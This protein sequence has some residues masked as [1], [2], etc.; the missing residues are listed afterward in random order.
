MKFHFD[1]DASN[2]VGVFG[3]RL[4]KSMRLHK[5]RDGFIKNSFQANNEHGCLAAKEL[6]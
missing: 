5:I 2:S 4:R 6:I 3:L 1:P